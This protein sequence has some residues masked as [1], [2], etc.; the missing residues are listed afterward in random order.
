MKT[1]EELQ[2]LI[3][4]HLFNELTRKNYNVK[5]TPANR[6]MKSSRFDI[7]FKLFYLEM[8]GFDASL[9]KKVYSEN[10]KACGLG[11]VFEYGNESKS[12]IE[13]F[14]YD[15]NLI[16]DSIRNND[17]DSDVSILPLSVNGAI[18]NGAHRHACCIYLNKNVCCINT[19]LENQ[20]QDYKFFYNRNVQVETLDVSALK[21]VEYA[22]NVHVA[23]IWPSAI[24]YDDKLEK[25]FPNI[26]YRKNIKLN[27]KGAHN[28]ISQIYSGEEW[29]GDL[30]D[31][32]K[33]AQ[34][35]AIEC[36]RN[37]NPV[38]IIFFQSDDFNE[39]LKIKEKVREIYKIGK[40]SIHITDTKEEAVKVSRVV[41]N[42][43]G[44]HFLNCA[45]P[46]RIPS[47]FEKINRFKRMLQENNVNNSDVLLDSSIVLS[48]YGLRE[49]RD[50][51]FLCRDN[52]CF[53]TIKKEI[54][55][56]D[57]ELKYYEV[58]KAELI[59]NQNYYFYFDGL[60]FVSFQALYE[61]KKKRGEEKDINDCKMMQALVNNNNSLLRVHKIRQNW[62]YLKVK[63][64]VNLVN[65]LK[66]IKLYS[67]IRFTYRKIMRGKSGK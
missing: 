63:L 27:S 13:K 2:D 26:V 4:P 46:G 53:K 29:V 40:H 16:L 55:F 58:G 64:R 5:I 12:S 3:E 65:F 10:I 54:D 36:F 56:H 38:R 11:R 39:V 52:D 37:F 60:K 47:T 34:N 33:G 61:M 21:F 6:L 62:F 43:N 31:N 49:A 41:L 35:K 51:D 20:V 44:I 48:L 23:F 1:K 17:F 67:L 19:E 32:Y 24:G 42:K 22:E 25:V 7:G 30:S 59:Y 9:A 66:I 28:L 14:E 50:I 15:F 45:S 18:A 8:L 57:G